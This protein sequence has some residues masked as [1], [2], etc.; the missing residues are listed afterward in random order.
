VIFCYCIKI[1]PNPPTIA[2]IETNTHPPTSWLED[3]K[4][5]QFFTTVEKIAVYLT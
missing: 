3:C 1:S 4:P 2:L 5:C